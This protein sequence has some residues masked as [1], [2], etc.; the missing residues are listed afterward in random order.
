M[1]KYAGLAVMG[2]SMLMM[3]VPQASAYSYHRVDVSRCVAA[4]GPMGGVHRL[5]RT[6]TVHGVTHYGWY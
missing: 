2:L 1:I 6:W 4:I 3:S 5:C